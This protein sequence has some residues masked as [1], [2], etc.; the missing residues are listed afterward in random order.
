VRLHTYMACLHVSLPVIFEGL[1]HHDKRPECKYG[2]VSLCI[3][4]QVS[5]IKYV[6][7]LLH[8][9]CLGCRALWLSSLVDSCILLVH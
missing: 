6:Y 2:Q 1:S 7:A 9:I 4:F 5:C 8:K 3:Q